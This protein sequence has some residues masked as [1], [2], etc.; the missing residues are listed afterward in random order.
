MQAKNAKAARGITGHGFALSWNGRA[1][2][3]PS[4]CAESED[5]ALR[6][7]KNY[8]AGEPRRT[9]L[10]RSA[11]RVTPWVVLLAM[12]SAGCTYY[13]AR[14]PGRRISYEEKVGREFAIEASGI[15]RL[16]DEPEVLDFVK[17][18]G[19]RIASQLTGSNTTFRFYVIRDPTM[20]AFAVPGGYIYIYAGLLAQVASADEL[21]GVVAHEIGHVEGNHF[22]R[23]QKK[24]DV[25]SIATVA[26]TILAAALGGGEQAVAVGTLAQATQLSTSLHY[27]RQFERE[28]DRTSILIAF[29]AGFDP[30]G[31]LSLFRTFQAEA[32]LNA[33]D[34]PPYFYTHPLPMERLYEVREWLQLMDLPERH[35]DPIRGF[36]L[37]RLTARL[38]TENDERV[39]AEHEKLARENPENSRNQ[40]LLGYLYLKRGDLTRAEQHLA[41]S[42]RM[43]DSV[44]EYRLYLAKARQLAG[45]LEQS[46]TLLKAAIQKEPGNPLA[47]IFY[48]DLLVQRQD[49]DAALLQYSKARVFGPDSSAAHLGLGMIYGRMGRTGESYYYLGL[50]EKYAGRYL[51][52]HYYFKRAIGLLP[53]KSKEAQAA[54]EEI[55]WIEG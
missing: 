25:A 11:G 18:M 51:K 4:V 3:E 37:A 50:A 32:R 53:P 24:M 19:H 2:A 29:K 39:F 20:N 10:P 16:M 48:G 6:T 45:E 22:I 1:A 44:S 31:I 27:S 38:R 23:G 14:S 21:A 26:A 34:L 41:R 47:Q 5:R 52:A 55:H 13:H 15:L 36:D 42:V 43:D 8:Q 49:Y 46:E 17:A 40:F 30:Q 35:Q 7:T 33:S 9:C 28:A 54:G 12:L